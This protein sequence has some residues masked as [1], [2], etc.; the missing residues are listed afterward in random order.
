[1][2][3]VYNHLESIKKENILY[4]FKQEQKYCP[5]EDRLIIIENILKQYD[6]KKEDNKISLQKFHE[7]IDKINKII[8]NNTWA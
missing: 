6:R 3:T 4:R 1:M 8:Y 7:S 2:D 5:S